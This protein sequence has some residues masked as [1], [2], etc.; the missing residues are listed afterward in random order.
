MK[1]NPARSSARIAVVGC[2]A[3]GM[4][5]FG[6]PVAAH[7]TESDTPST[8]KNVIVLIGDG[9]GYNHVDVANLWENGT[10]Q[11]Q[12]TVDPATGE[13]THH[14]STATQVF[15]D[16][17]VR[18]GQSHYSANGIAE[19]VTEDAWGSFDQVK[20]GATDSAAA[21]TA[22]GTG[23]KT[24]N[25][26]LG[27]DPAGE[28][29]L[30]ITEQA[31]AVG[32]STGVV[33]SVPFSHATPAA[34]VAHNASRNDLAGVA[35]EMYESDLDVIIGAG[36]PN[37]DDDHRSRTAKYEYIGE[38]EWTALN[39]GDSPW[40]F[41]ESRRD[42]EA[43]AAGEKA[44]PERIFGI[45]QVA[46]TLQQ[47]RAGAHADELPGEAPL[48]DVPGLDTLSQVALNTLETNDEGF[49]L[50]IEG[51]A[52]DWTGHANQTGRTIEE[53][54]D[55]NKAIETV[56]TW[57]EENSSW[58]ETLVVVTAD[59]ET[60]YLAGAGAGETWTPMTG[61]AGELPDVSWH[62]GNHTN[63]LVPVYAKGAGSDALEARATSWDIVRGAYLDNTDIAEVI[64][65]LL[66]HAEGD[67]SDGS[68]PLT[69]QLGAGPGEGALSL[70]VTGLDGS[71]AFDAT[72]SAAL[73]ATL[74][75]IA[76]TDTRTEVD[77]RGK[78]WTVSGQASEFFAGNRTIGAEYLGWTP[79]VLESAGGAA[80]GSTVETAIDGGDGLAQPAVLA[81][82]DRTTRI[83]QTTVDAELALTPPADA[84]AGNYGSTITVT[85]FAQD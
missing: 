62:S 52:I 65:D 82:S 43:I 40:E 70:A 26:I 84:A 55:F 30:N 4:T 83:G 21:G 33:S 64:F 44:A 66:G 42:F 25:G 45:P 32:K 29:L 7:A 27:I 50:M 49:F 74:P 35:K 73:A 17:P 37:F 53:Q 22:L 51:G 60:G 2:V 46:T 47:N 16:Y 34:Y 38:P 54:V 8:P 68:I 79:R 19:Y 69:A 56:D 81:A 10:S 78:G 11:N 9:M 39:S 72:D 23:V 41:V 31:E 36:H 5:A 24:N 1:K 67:G 80:A 76:V 75:E 61:A 12:V 28:Q 20:E 63:A 85:L 15:E 71:V 77:A 57:V 59:H 18:V 48:N 58:D 14:E 13:V 3:L 6:L